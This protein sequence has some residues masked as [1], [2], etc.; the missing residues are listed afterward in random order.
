MER[1]DWS[2]SPVNTVIHDTLG[3]A[4]VRQINFTEVIQGL[5]SCGDEG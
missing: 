2:G 5:Y 3:P 4:S 1:G